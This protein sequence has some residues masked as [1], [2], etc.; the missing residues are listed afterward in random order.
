[1]HICYL[2]LNI[3]LDIVFTA[4]PTVLNLIGLTRLK[5]KDIVTTCMLLENEQRVIFMIYLEP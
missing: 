4:G 3:L 1:M 2:H 5:A